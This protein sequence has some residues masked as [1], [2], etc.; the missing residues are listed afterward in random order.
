[1][2]P[3]TRKFGLARF[4]RSMS[5]LISSGLRIDH[6]IENSAAVVSNP[7]LEKDLLKALPGVRDG[8]TLVEAFSESRLLTPTAREMLYVGEE[9]GSLD[10]TLRKVSEY[11]LAEATHA[12]QVATKI[13]GVLIALIVGGLVGYIIIT[14]YS[15]LYGG[16]L[17]DLGV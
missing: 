1:M 6:C 15:R 3:V 2:S 8:Q 7:Y 10:Q 11:H 13:L 9:S 16:M 12:V 4:F 14:F 17:D 5:L